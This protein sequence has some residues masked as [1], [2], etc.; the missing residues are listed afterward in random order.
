MNAIIVKDRGRYRLVKDY[1]IDRNTP[2]GDPADFFERKPFGGNKYIE[3]PEAQIEED[4]RITFDSYRCFKALYDKAY[5]YLGDEFVASE[6]L[7]AFI[8]TL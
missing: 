2:V 1:W 3:N 4:G 5:K 7:L 6:K 8:K